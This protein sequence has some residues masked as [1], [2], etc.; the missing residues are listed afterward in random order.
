MKY[1]KQTP[2]TKRGIQLALGA[3]WLLD[4]ALQLQHQ[5]FSSNFATQV[6]A[7]A[8]QGQPL[9]VYG[10]IN[11]EIHMLLLH[12]ALFDTFFALIQLTLGVLI[13]RKRTARIGL[14]GSVAWGLAV[15]YMGE[16]LGGLLSGRT[17]LLVG[18][19]GAALLYAILALAVLPDRSNKK[20]TETTVRPAYWLPVVWAGLWVLGA[21]YQLLPGQNTAPDIASA[22]ASTAGGGSPGWLSSLAIHTANFVNGKGF[23]FVLMLALLQAVIGL[24]VLLPGQARKLAVGMGVA[25]SLVFWFVGQSLGD[26]F[27]GLATDPNTA[28]LFILLG[29]AMLGTT[30]LDFKLL[31]HSIAKVCRRLSHS[32]D[33]HRTPAPH[34]QRLPSS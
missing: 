3:L 30:Q 33:G 15:W 6:I 2:I 4:G 18:A 12:P 29:I 11:F 32:M 24:L 9:P 19:P 14:L 5:M 7:P 31:K 28:P 26:Y 25:L 8:G 23:G 22:I 17:M 21:I 10:P 13:L 27:S 1:Q 34:S 16:G 20:K